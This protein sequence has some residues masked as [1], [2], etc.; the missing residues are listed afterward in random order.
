MADVT[1]IQAGI[2]NSLF[3]LQVLN[4]RIQTL[5]QLGRGLGPAIGK[6]A[7]GGLGGIL[8][9]EIFG[10]ARTGSVSYNLTKKLVA[11]GQ[12]QQSA[13]EKTRMEYEFNQIIQRTLPLLSQVSVERP[14]LKPRGNRGQ[15]VLRIKRIAGFVKLET[16]VLR[17]IQLLQ[18]LQQEKLLLNK[19]IPEA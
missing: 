1:E 16:K 11:S 2:A 12:A 13:A 7:I 17:G 10:S 3:Q 9:Q 6:E 8:A 19:D 15:L 5:A 4:Q 14:S 18:S